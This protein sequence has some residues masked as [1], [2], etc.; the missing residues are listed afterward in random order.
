MKRVRLFLY[1]VL[2]VVVVGIIGAG[3]ISL[4]LDLN[5]FKPLLAEA[6][7]QETGRN[8]VIDGDVE[9]SLFPRPRATATGIRLSNVPGGSEADAITVK[10]ASVQVGWLSLFTG[11]IDVKSV[12]ANGVQI[13]VEEGADAQSSLA[14]QPQDRDGGVG[15]PSL[16]GLIEVRDVS[17]TFRTGPTDNVFDISRLSL[18]PQGPTG[19][20]NVDLNLV[21]NGERVSI[22]GQVGNLLAIAEPA[23]FPVALTAS[24][25]RSTLNLEGSLSGLGRLPSLDLSVTG[26]GPSIADLSRVVG[27]QLP[28]SEPFVLA[29]R[30]SGPLENIQ[31]AD[32]A[33][34]AGTTRLLGDAS[35]D[36]TA[37][38]PRITARIHSPGLDLSMTLDEETA[39]PA[40]RDR[41]VA[42]ANRTT[43]SEELLPFGFSRGFDAD[44]AIQ[45]EAVQALG[46]TFTDASLTF[47]T[48][49]GLMEI[50][51]LAAKLP[52]GSLIATGTLDTRTDEAILSVA[53]DVTGLD[54]AKVLETLN[55]PGNSARRADAHLELASRGDTPR[56]LMDNLTAAIRLSEL[57]VS[58]KDA[59]RLVLTGA[60]AQFDG[61]DQPINVTARGTFRDVSVDIMGR[62]DPL[63]SYRPGAPYT[64]QLTASGGG[65]T[66]EVRADMRAAMVDGLTLHTSISGQNLADLSKL[67][68]LPMPEAGPY[69][70]VGVLVFADD[71]ITL[72]E[73]DI[74]IADSDV[75]GDLTLAFGGDRTKLVGDFRAETIDL[76]LVGLFGAAP[77]EP[78][79]AGVDATDDRRPPQSVDGILNDTPLDLR[80][81]LVIDTE[82]SLTAGLVK[83]GESLLRDVTT[84]VNSDRQALRLARFSARLDG[85]TLAAS[86]VA[87]QTSDQLQVSLKVDVA[88]IDAA[89]LVRAMGLAE[90][91]DAGDL[92]L[93]SEISSVGATSRE[94]FDNAAGEVVARQLRFAV[95]TDD[96]V[97]HEQIVLDSLQI[98]TKGAASA[99]TVQASG[100]LGGENLTIEASLAPLAELRG[101]KPVQLDA[102]MTTPSSHVRVRGVAPDRAR[103]QDLDFTISAEGLIVREIAYAAG[104]TLDAAG[105]WRIQGALTTTG[106]STELKEFAVA[107][108]QSDLTGNVRMED[109]GS[110]RRLFLR[111]ASENFDLTDFIRLDADDPGQ[112]PAIEATGGPLFSSEPINFE[113]L[114]GLNLDVGVQLKAFS[115][116]SMKGRDFAVTATA[117]NGVADVQRFSA[118]VGDNPVV[119][120]AQL[121]LRGDKAKL[122]VSLTGGPF[123]AGAVALELS[124]SNLGNVL[125]LPVEVG[126][127]VTSTGNS[128]HELASLMTG[129]V[130]LTGG[131]GF[132]QQRAFRFLD[133]G[134]LRQLA[135]W[136]DGKR[137]RTQINCF[138][139]RFD[140]KEGV[141]TS[142]ALL[143]DAEFISIAGKGSIDLGRETLNLTLTPRP[144]E[145]RL[146]DLAVPIAVTGPFGEP[147]VLPTAGGT[148][149]KVATT[150]GIFVNPLVLLV[151]V[152][153]GVTAEK[154]PCLAAIERADSGEANDGQNGVVGGVI[155]GIGDVGRGIGRVLGGGKEE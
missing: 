4:F 131:N 87:Q 65:A 13:L 105:P 116:R 67:I 54:V 45:A 97:A 49:G 73:A 139:G 48:V 16:P 57:E 145:V 95:K 59:A 56:G 35:L 128:A 74:R 6:A 103:P 8:L 86:G 47:R 136:D 42:E 83:A 75:K 58:F 101:L 2:T 71:A 11:A 134:I 80:P 114:R 155:R 22:S 124:R 94:L 148:A 85:E 99:V 55:V 102:S 34:D 5:R 44:V 141:A 52:E 29:T 33:F 84:E 10:I 14:F 90:R 153:E 24:T 111:A 146:L 112:E 154:N 68:E 115:G 150:L 64:F 69:S 119:G 135:P 7:L 9:L 142:R 32:I 79:A 88:G 122:S 61:R 70:A 26:Q 19:P 30:L 98:A 126:I 66:A 91:I 117:D 43:V 62:L 140:V 132:I 143:L 123:D 28:D 51:R 147:K 78:A 21:L 113:P 41:T 149:K 46:L 3:L 12:H 39:E 81:F 127:E 36:L 40:P 144:K 18:R 25:A 106:S 37:Q 121:D 107:V 76:A 137:D 53:A 108:G 60:S 120:R 133:Q 129:T 152:I 96:V 151:P 118:T 31:A 50:E 63:A 130:S 92:N 23:S 89:M 72:R 110:G 17:L 1:G 100:T 138:V 77:D 104:L 93:L 20:T 27:V 125:Q 82:V 38:R 15:Q 109:G